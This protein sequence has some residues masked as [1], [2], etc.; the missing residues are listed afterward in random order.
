MDLEKGEIVIDNTSVIALS[1]HSI[2]NVYNL[3]AAY[4]VCALAGI[5]RNLIADSIQHYALKNGR[6]VNFRM[7]AHAG[8]LLTSKHENSVS[9]DQSLRLVSQ[10][11]TP[12]SAMIIVDAVSR[13]YFTSEISWLWD[14]DFSQLRTNTLQRVML[15]GTYAND[16]AV[17]FFFTDIPREKIMVEEDIGK[18]VDTFVQYGNEPV[19]AITC[20]SDKDKLLGRVTVL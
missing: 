11:K 14:I 12:Y 20:F 5:E 9:Y 8:T 10:C 3:L 7:G 4:A 6:V 16:L 15:C 19:F 18:A 1:L 2:Y 13:K 17:R